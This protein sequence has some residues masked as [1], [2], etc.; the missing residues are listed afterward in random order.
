MALVTANNSTILSFTNSLKSYEVSVC[1][2]L[3]NALDLEAEITPEFLSVLIYQWAFGE[4]GHNLW[5]LF[6]YVIVFWT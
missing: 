4:S 3:N 5:E 2:V 6:V 1:Y